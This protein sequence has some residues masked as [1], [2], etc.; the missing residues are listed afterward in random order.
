MKFLR[1]SSSF[2]M[3]RKRKL[4]R[5]CG[6]TTTDEDNASVIS[7]RSTV[8]VPDKPYGASSHSSSSLVSE[9]DRPRVRF[10]E[11]K[12]VHHDNISFGSQNN[13]DDDDDKYRHV[14]WLSAD[15]LKRCKADAV[16]MAKGILLW[17][18]GDS[19]PRPF[20]YSRQ[21]LD[22]YQACCRRPLSQAIDP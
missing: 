14:M 3:I 16:T 18:H 1:L 9:H 12:N 6:T 22:V 19:L 11:S 4:Q 2:G 21:V 13:D 17:E 5:G 15:E 8:T 20:T 10:D 7:A